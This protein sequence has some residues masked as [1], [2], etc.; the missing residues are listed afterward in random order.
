M[1]VNI[2]LAD[3]ATNVYDYITDRLE[4]ALDRF[5]SLIEDI[6]VR[7]S[8]EDSSKSSSAYRCTMDATLAAGGVLHVHSNEESLHAAIAESARK[9]KTS[10]T[11]H[12]D[13]HNRARTI[14][15]ELG[16]AEAGR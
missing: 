8:E 7:A 1:K 11:K 6:S 16:R 15:H 2:H 4:T 3:S 12:L 5:R 9:L 14:R 10:L 13:R